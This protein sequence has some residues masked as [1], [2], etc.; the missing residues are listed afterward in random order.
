MQLKI[1]VDMPDKLKMFLAS[2]DRYINDTIK[3]ADKD[4]L[5][6]LKENIARTAPR[7]SGQLASSIT[8]DFDKRKVYATAVYAR[9]VELG[10]YAE[11]KNTPKKMFMKFGSG[12]GEVFVKFVRTK[13]QPYFFKALNNSW[14]KIRDIYQKAIRQLLER[15]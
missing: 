13:K 1:K 6:Y 14:S 5:T 3:Q 7:K 11:P 10:H 15:I 9:A 12:S 2:P 4:A 8:T